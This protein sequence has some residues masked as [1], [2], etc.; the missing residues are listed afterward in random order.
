MLSFDAMLVDSIQ[1]GRAE[2]DQLTLLGSPRP[3]A[4][5]PA[6]L[7]H[8]EVLIYHQTAQTMLGITSRGLEPEL[9]RSPTL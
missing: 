2:E 5:P 4:Q 9:E 8:R 3:R 1:S 6:P 7:G